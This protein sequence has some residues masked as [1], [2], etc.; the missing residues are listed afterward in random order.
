MGTVSYE[1]TAMKKTPKDLASSPIITVVN[2]IVA[3]TALTSIA[4]KAVPSAQASEGKY[5]I[6]AQKDTGFSIP[7]MRT[8][9]TVGTQSYI[10]YNGQ[11]GVD[12]SKTTTDQ[13]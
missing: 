4:T 10:G 9:N 13:W 6:K 3:A 1:F 5:D 2:S 11:Y 12:D 8:Y 7:E